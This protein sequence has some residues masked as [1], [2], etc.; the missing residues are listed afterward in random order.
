VLTAPCAKPVVS[1]A[2]RARFRPGRC[3]PR[4]RRTVFPNGAVD[5]LIV[6]TLQETVQSR[7]IRHAGKPK[8][9]TQFA[10]FAEPHL[11]FAKGPVFVTHQAKNGEQ[12]RLRK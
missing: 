1:T 3:E 10:M 7:E 4:N 11:G 9:L 6:Q 2:T 12:L 5:D 8:A